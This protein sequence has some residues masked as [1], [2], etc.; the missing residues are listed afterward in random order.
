[1]EHDS[2]KVAQEFEIVKELLRKDLASV[3]L[4][5]RKN[6]EESNKEIKELHK[7][8]TEL[9]ES[10]SKI[11]KAMETRNNFMEKRY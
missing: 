5:Q 1:M 7:I 2:K 6:K 3:I 4:E 8:I 11:M 9:K 10:N